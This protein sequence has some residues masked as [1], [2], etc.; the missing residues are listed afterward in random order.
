MTSSPTFSVV[1]ACHNE[2]ENVTPLLERLGRVFEP[3]QQT[4]EVVLIDD[5]STDA[6]LSVALES[7]ARHPELT[8]VELSRNFGHQAAVTAGF[9]IARGQAIILMDADLQDPPEVVPEMI[10]KWR[11][12]YDVAY[13]QR[14]RREGETLFKRVS[15][16]LFYRLFRKI[17][18]MN[19]PVD[20]GEFR[21]MDRKVVEALK[22]MTERQRFLRGMVTWIGY[23]QTTVPY[24]RA[25]RQA[26]ETHYPLRAMLRLAWDAFASFTSFPIHCLYYAGVLLVVVGLVGAVMGLSQLGDGR[27]G[28]LVLALSGVASVLTGI[29]LLGMKVLGEYI[30]RTYEE[31]KKRPLYLVRQVHRV[32]SGGPLPGRDA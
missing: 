26:G 19:L 16:A 24:S 31:T 21:L 7:L 15:A 14:I 4:Y 23:R 28:P 6:T 20:T 18:R 9:E 22:Q 5:G 30:S 2:A 11:E 25:A 1:V 32:G 10:R 13:G 27:Q 12:G 29:L 3:L 17:S 8:V